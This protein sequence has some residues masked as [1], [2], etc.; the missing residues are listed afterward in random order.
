MGEPGSID[1]G[2]L[3]QEPEAPGIS[4]RAVSLEGSRWAIVDYAP[5]AARREWCADGHRGYVVSGAVEYEFADGRP[6]LRVGAEQAFRLP[7]AP[8]HRGR[9][10]GDGAARLFLI[11]DPA[12]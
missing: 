12:R 4:S 6:A 2:A 1:F 7:P 11:D 5:G 3:T 10:V 9:N 8:P